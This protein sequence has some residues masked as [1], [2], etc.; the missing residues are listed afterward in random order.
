[1]TIVDVETGATLFR[2]G[3][4]FAARK[5]KSLVTVYDSEKVKPSVQR[6]ANKIVSPQVPQQM[7]FGPPR[8]LLHG[9]R[10]VTV[11]L[12]NDHQV[13]EL[14]VQ[15]FKPRLTTRTYCLELDS[16]R[17]KGETTQSV[18]YLCEQSLL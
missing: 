1:M 10:G 12:K 5:L 15:A 16:M 3:H 18:V 17:H 6:R 4:V 13:Q 11:L 8:L 9:P 7:N 14:S 2:I